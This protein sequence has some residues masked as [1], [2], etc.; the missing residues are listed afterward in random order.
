MTARERDSSKTR[1]S[2]CSVRVENHNL[3]TAAVVVCVLA[4]RTITVAEATEFC[5]WRGKAP[6]CAGQCQSGEAEVFRRGLADPFVEDIP[7]ATFG[8]FGDE[9][10]TGSK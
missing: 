10:V 6:L 9:C 4:L 3:I 1:S 2:R 7:G 5:V 8:A